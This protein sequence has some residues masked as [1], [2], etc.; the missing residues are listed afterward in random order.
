VVRKGRLAY[1]EAAAAEGVEGTCVLRV[2]VGEKGEVIE[3]EVTRSSGDRRLDKVA[4]DFVRQ[5]RYRPAVQDG[6]P[7]RV[8]TRA[9]VQFALN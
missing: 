9:T 3:V 7:R 4:L 6:K 1:P 2:L 8:N 5:W